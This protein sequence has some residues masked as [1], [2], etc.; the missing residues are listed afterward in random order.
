MIDVEMPD[1]WVGILLNFLGNSD[2]DAKTIRITKRW[3]HFFQ[4]PDGRQRHHAVAA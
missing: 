2:H 4:K 1:L 3:Q